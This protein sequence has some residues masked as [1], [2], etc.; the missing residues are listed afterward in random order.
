MIEQSK[1]YNISDSLGYSFDNY[2]QKTTRQSKYHNF[3]D[4]LGY[5]FDDSHQLQ[6]IVPHRHVFLPP[7]ARLRFGIGDCN[8]VARYTALISALLYYVWGQIFVSMSMIL[9]VCWANLKDLLFRCCGLDS[10]DNEQRLGAG[11]L[12]V[13]L[14]IYLGVVCNMLGRQVQSGWSAWSCVV[15]IAI[16]I[17]N[18]VD[19]SNMLPWM[20]ILAVGAVVGFSK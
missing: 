8:S 17:L 20:V 7:G 1:Y 15:Y 10:G 2:A 19:N 13:R 6:S 5:P 18:I 9:R 12:F 4:S 16:F 14:F 3:W 11:Y